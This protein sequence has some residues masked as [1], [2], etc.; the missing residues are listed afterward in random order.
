MDHRNVRLHFTPTYSSGL[1]QVEIWFGKLQ[2]DVIARGIFTSVTDLRRK[3]MRYI[4]LYGKTAKPFQ[5]K[6]SN[7]SHRIQPW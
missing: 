2:R 5:W 4:R 7:P 3:I 6:Y 1:N